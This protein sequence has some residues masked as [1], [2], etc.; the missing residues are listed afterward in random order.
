M[1][2]AA[3]DA[4]WWTQL[5]Q[6]VEQ[7]G[8]SILLATDHFTESF[9]PVPAL[10]AAGAVTQKLRLGTAV[11]CNDYKHPVVLAKEVA[12][13]DVLSQGRFELGL[14]AG[15]MK[16]DYEAAG[17]PYDEPKVRIDRM[18]E[19]L[20]IIKALLADGPVHFEGQ[21][22]RIRD[23]EGKP[24]PVQR[25]HP[26]IFIG[27]GGKRMLSVA[28]RQADIVGINADLRG[29]VVDAQVFEQ[30]SLEGAQQKVQWVRD[31]AGQRFDDLEL[32]MTSFVTIITD[33]PHAAA[34]KSADK[35]GLSAEALLNSPYTLIGNVEQVADKIQRRR[36][37]LGIS[38]STIMADSI[39]AF[40]PIVERLAGR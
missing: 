19:G 38:Y 15:W 33:D 22:Y 21:H 24:K 10:A 12:T 6:R 9:A 37:Q 11:F 30:L 26:P 14:G 34:S 8:Y 4:A 39:E 18:E 23:L 28:A 20:H 25:P 36:E 3:G 17:M 35:M 31:A 7:L 32:T 40:A 5:A 13:L 29:G 27:G 16:F 2:H 1:A